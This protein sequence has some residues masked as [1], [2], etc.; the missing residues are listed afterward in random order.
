MPDS[1]DEFDDLFSFST[2]TPKNAKARTGASSSSPIDFDLGDSFTSGGTEPSSSAN[3]TSA[4]DFTTDDTGTATAANFG[5][6]SA[7]TSDTGSYYKVSPTTTDPASGLDDK[8]GHYGGNDQDTSNSDDA[9]DIFGEFDIGRSKVDVNANIDV[10]GMSMNSRNQK[11]GHQEDDFH[12]IDRDTREFLDFLD[13]PKKTKG[14]AVV[15]IEGSLSK[16]LA[17]LGLDDDDDDEDGMMDFVDI[18]QGDENQIGIKSDAQDVE[19]TS[20]AATDPNAS[21]VLSSPMSKDVKTPS[22]PA[23]TRTDASM[24]DK[25]SPI[26]SPARTPIPSSKNATPQRSI[27]ATTEEGSSNTNPDQGKGDKTSSPQKAKTIPSLASLQVDGAQLKPLW[28]D[29]TDNDNNGDTKEMNTNEPDTAPDT[30]ISATVSAPSSTATS[31]SPPIDPDLNK[32]HIASMTPEKKVIV[33]DNLVD[34]IH[35]PES[36]MKEIRPL[37]FPHST[38]VVAIDNDE[39]PWLW[40]KVI[41]SKILP[42]IQSSSLADSFL[43]WDEGFDMDALVSGADCYGLLEDFIKRLLNEVELVVKRILA[44][45]SY[46]KKEDGSDAMRDLCSLLLYYYRSNAR[47][48]EGDSDGTSS[49]SKS[50]AVEVDDSLMLSEDVEENKP[51]VENA[52]PSEEKETETSGT[53]LKGDNDAEKE[54]TENHD[55]SSAGEPKKEDEIPTEEDKKASLSTPKGQFVEWNPLIAPVAATLLACG[56]SKEVSSVMLSRIVPAFMPLLS[57]M[58]TERMQGVRTLH[59]KLYYL[60]CYHMP[61]LVLHLDRYIPGWY[62]PQAKST[63]DGE[64]EKSATQ[65]SR[66][67]E[68]QGIIPITWF[69][70]LLAGESSV[71]ALETNRLLALWDV[72]LCSPDQSLKFFLALSVL[73]RNSDHLLM[74]KGQELI[75]ELTAVMNL[76]RN[77]VVMESFTEGT[78]SSKESLGGAQ[79]YVRTW[80]NHAKTLMETTPLSVVQNLQTAEDEAVNYALNLRSKIAM[81][82]MAARLEA[83]N[84]AHRRALEIEN[85]R[86]VELRMEKYYKD[87]LEKFYKKN[88]PEKLS[89]V[90]HIMELYKDKYDILDKKLHIK[91]GRGFL[92]LISVFTPKVATQTGQM[93]SNVNQ[94]LEIKKKNIIAARAE[95][96]AKKIAANMGGEGGFQVSIQV[97]A[98]EI[99]P[100]VCTGLSSKIPP[101]TRD[102]LKYYL[103][104]SRPDETLKVQGAFPTAARL[105]PE[106]LMDPERIQQKIEMFESLRGGIHICI[107]GEGFSSFPTL[108]GHPLD[109]N[110]QKLLDNDQSRTSKFL[111]FPFAI[112]SVTLIVREDLPFDRLQTCVLSSLSKEDSRLYLCL[113]VV[114]RLH[115]HG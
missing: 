11:V 37:L 81:E 100:V 2:A 21:D 33:F 99:M 86:K 41:C 9:D 28:T 48:K 46:Q 108:Y 58:D 6:A 94:G 24:G 79:E 113:T 30:T 8:Q 15:G 56:T 114:L 44:S 87:R 97:T 74:L 59:Q 66:N 76:E 64:G 36:T 22:S 4:A 26:P 35:S 42:D 27:P 73:E 68:E 106:D 98:D 70:S 102:P 90:D 51:M 104:D 85:A 10:M 52:I 93:L 18:D 84:E 17:D 45:N 23:K 14:D 3:A 115:M 75:D 77:D 78:S 39:R 12:A 67:L 20:S 60:I 83:E 13:E 107:M 29:D 91:Y 63:S 80:T 7:H 43:N 61:L 32:V 71:E 47:G 55:A 65:I 57:L 31:A 89:S 101:F 112:Y 16:D 96:R 110:E 40:S 69:S 82:K 5:T 103:V 19:N 25:Q 34:A 49:V 105:S 62:W 50:K 38:D 95:E 54:N 109:K 111:F 72:L 1:D 88:C 53:E 92:P